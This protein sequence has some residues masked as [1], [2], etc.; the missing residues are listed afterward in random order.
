MAKATENTDREQRVVI[1]CRVEISHGGRRATGLSQDLSS[2]GVFVRT[3]EGLP[4]GTE[5]QIKLHLPSG[6]AIET[7]ARVAHVLA[8]EAARALGRYPGMGL[9]FVEP[10]P[11]V[12]RRLM[13]Q[14]DELL[15]T[16]GPS[17]D[18][19]G[20]RARVLVVDGST[21]LL[22]RL[23][24]ALGNAGFVVATA[25]NGGEAYSACLESPPD[26]VLAAAEMPVMDG[27]KLVAT[28][29]TRPELAGIPVALMSDDAGDLTRL[30]AYRLGV[31]DFLPKPFTVA[32]V[33]IRMRRAARAHRASHERVVLRGS[34]AEIGM[35]TLLSM[36]E[37]ERKS[38]ILAVMNEAEAA[39]L[40][41]D[42]GRV[43]RVESPEGEQPRER[44]MKL[45]DWTSGDFQ[46]L[47]CRVEDRD[48]IGLS[49]TQLLLEHARRRDEEKAK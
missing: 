38:G 18:G 10:D 25:S 33:C 31:I 6:R 36:L 42:A 20:G 49:T 21:R 4:V 16:L 47:A 48:D 5:A 41:V 2:S 40:S 44:M 46:F 45:L 37:F 8:E 35:A 39:W 32:E 15:G 11:G 22:E 7:R 43:V 13:E 24:T 27:W 30:R 9:A 1:A 23:S 29:G 28:L 14:L 3:R 12:R 34:V 17:R 26:L 19:G